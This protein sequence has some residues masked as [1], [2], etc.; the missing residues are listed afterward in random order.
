MDYVKLSKLHQE[1]FGLNINIYERK[2]IIDV[3]EHDTSFLQ[4]NNLMD[5]SILIGIEQIQKR[6]ITLNENVDDSILN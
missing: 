1:I 5:Y 3:I 6:T 2:Q 4:A